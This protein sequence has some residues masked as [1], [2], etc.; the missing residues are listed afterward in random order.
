MAPRNAA[1][2]EGGKCQVGRSKR[3][4]RRPNLVK[5]KSGSE[6]KSL[7]KEREEFLLLL[8]EIKFPSAL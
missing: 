1:F 2:P 6:E 7:K 5:H 3:L 4:L 8:V